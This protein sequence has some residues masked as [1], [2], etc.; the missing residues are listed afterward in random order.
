M[1]S[2]GLPGGEGSG[3][4]GSN[5][6]KSLLRGPG[7]QGEGEIREFTGRG[8][9]REEAMGQRRPR[10]RVL[11]GDIEGDM[12]Q[13]HGGPGEPDHPKALLPSVYSSTQTDPLK[14]KKRCLFFYLFFLIFLNPPPVNKS[15]TNNHKKRG[16]V[17]SSRWLAMTGISVPVHPYLTAFVL[18]G[19]PRPTA[20]AS[21]TIAARREARLR[22]CRQQRP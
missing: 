15:K 21:P 11:H 8:R 14:K 9:G 12:P 18:G 4:C 7:G 3:C 22:A 5:V 17:I 13:G 2:Q 6:R 19:A 16:W 20:C 10:G 1:R